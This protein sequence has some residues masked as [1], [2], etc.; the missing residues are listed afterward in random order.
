M[1]R[2][3]LPLCLT[4]LVFAGCGKKPEP[5]PNIALCPEATIRVLQANQKF[6]DTV[7]PG[8]TAASELS[9]L[10]GMVR[11]ATLE[12]P[13]SPSM[14]VLFY[15]TNLPRCPWL[16]NY[17]SLTPVVIRDGMIEAIGTNGVK[18]YTDKGW[19]LQEAAWP[20]QSYSFGYI[21]Q[22]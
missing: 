6:F 5:D 11:K 4:A 17:E 19:K 15:E 8:K 9:G 20:W 18:R 12:L 2:Y 10:H 3:L 21:P 22:E 13:G 7:E 1:T 14:G 16:V